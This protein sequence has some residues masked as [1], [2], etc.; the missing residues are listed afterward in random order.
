MLNTKVSRTIFLKFAAQSLLSSRGMGAGIDLVEL[1]GVGI[2]QLLVFH[3]WTS[4]SS[5][6]CLLLLLLLLLWLSQWLLQWLL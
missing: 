2:L 1:H 4:A 3:L 6:C 5:C